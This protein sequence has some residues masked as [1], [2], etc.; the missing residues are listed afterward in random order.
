VALLIGGIEALGLIGDQFSLGGGFWDAIGALNENFNNLG[1]AIVGIFL[2]A[3]ILSYAFYKF[4]K[5]DDQE[6]ARGSR[7]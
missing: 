5:L 4:A 2:V 7:A 3:W 1:F 6:A